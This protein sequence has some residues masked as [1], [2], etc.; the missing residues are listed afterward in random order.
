MFCLV[1]AEVSKKELPQ[2]FAKCWP[3]WKETSR[4][5][6]RSALFPTSTAREGAPSSALALTT[7]WKGVGNTN[8]RCIRETHVLHL[9]DLSAVLFHLGTKPQ[10]LSAMRHLLSCVWEGATSSKEERCI[11]LY[12]M[13]KPSPPPIH[14]ERRA[15]Y[16]SWPAVSSTSST[17]TESSTTTC[18]R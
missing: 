16:S 11:I 7:L 15:E 10:R 18:L 1:L 5:W 13:R 17:Q 6:V 2:S 4:S 12:R 9:K 14:C 8:R 3:S